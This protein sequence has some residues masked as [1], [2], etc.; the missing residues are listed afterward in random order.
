MMKKSFMTI[1]G[2]AALGYAVRRFLPQMKAVVE[3]Y[4]APK[5]THKRHAK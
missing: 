2:F 3:D 5:K 1:A 4:K